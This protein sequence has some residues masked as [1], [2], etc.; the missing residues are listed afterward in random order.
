MARDIG[1]AEKTAL[2]ERNPFPELLFF[3]GVLSIINIHYIVSFLCDP[4]MEGTVVC[5]LMRRESISHGMGGESLL[6]RSYLNIVK[7]LHFPA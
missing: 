3:G 1:A 7:K 2:N 5:G 4:Q 6:W